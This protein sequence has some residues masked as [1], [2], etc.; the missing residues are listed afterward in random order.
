MLTHA[1]YIYVPT[2]YHYL[3]ILING[4]TD[5]LLGGTTVDYY[6]VKVC[7]RYFNVYLRSCRHHIL[8]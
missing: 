4:P 1:N 5:L 6:E 3:T 2:P 7:G 8:V